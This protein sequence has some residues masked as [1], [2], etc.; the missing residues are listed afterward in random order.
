MT[1]VVNPQAR[2]STLVDKF[3]VAGDDRL[4]GARCAVA[5][6]VS[7]PWEYWILFLKEHTPCSNS[8]QKCTR[9]FLD[10]GKFS[11]TKFWHLQSWNRFLSEGVADSVAK[12]TFWLLIFSIAAVVRIADSRLLRGSSRIWSS[13][14][15]KVWQFVNFHGVYPEWLLAPHRFAAEDWNGVIILIVQESNTEVQ[16]PQDS[17]LKPRFEGG[18]ILDIPAAGICNEF[19]PSPHSNGPHPPCITGKSSLQY[20]HRYNNDKELRSK[21]LTWARWHYDIHRCKIVGLSLFV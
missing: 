20:R 16:V 15:P 2:K 3:Q 7:W 11:W 10:W 5:L 13:S 9:Q 19:P 14:N 21:Q 8:W 4:K 12:V 18:R 17:G 1:T 6:K